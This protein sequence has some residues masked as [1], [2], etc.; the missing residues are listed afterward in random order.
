MEFVRNQ[1]TFLLVK[2]VK[3]RFCRAQTMQN[4]FRTDFY[5]S[6]AVCS[7][8]R[9]RAVVPPAGADDE[10]GRRCLSVTDGLARWFSPVFRIRHSSCGLLTVNFVIKIGNAFGS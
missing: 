9:D 4:V 7:S 3:E 5:G 8:R 6:I 2:I 1:R 10:L